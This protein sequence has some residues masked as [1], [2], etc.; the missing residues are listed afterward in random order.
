MKGFH[1]SQ[2]I[3]GLLLLFAGVFFTGQIAQAVDFEL[4]GEL[5]PRF[6]YIDQGTLGATPGNAKNYTTMRTRVNVKAKADENTAAFVQIQDVRTW[7]GETPTSAP[8]SLTRTGTNTSASGLDLHQA[9]I[10]LKDVLD[11]GV[12]LKIGRQE[13]IYDEH[14]LLGNINWI[15]QG[16]SHDAALADFSLGELA[17][18]AFVAQTIAND[19]HPTLAAQVYTAA[20][21]NFE[22]FF[23]GLRATYKLGDNGDRITPY[24]YFS[25]DPAN[26]SGTVASRYDNLH[27]AGAYFL[28]HFGGFRFR[29]DGAYQFGKFGVGTTATARQDVQAYM[30]TGAL[31]TDVDIAHGGGITLWYDYLSGDKDTSATST[32]YKTFNTLYA[33]NHAYYG[34]M[35]KFLNTPTRGLQDAAIKFWVKPTEKLK[36]LLDLHQ[37][38][39]AAT[40][41][42]EGTNLGQEVDFKFVYPLAANTK[43][44]GGYS[45]YF[46]KG[47]VSG[48]FPGDTTLNGNWAWAMVDMKF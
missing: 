1:F 23:G 43:L 42:G 35:D 2:G 20:G 11:S 39:R 10:D 12:S 33:T 14:R 29:F 36:L 5:R 32:K 27:T 44:I 47:T 6:E 28:K 22:S 8:P 25:Q 46:G 7:G 30:L 31:G 13:I 34:H 19:T 38:M 41:A 26:T 16:Q 18:T 48:G 9:Y 24:Y 15:Q 17:V 3:R 4:G 21:N 37:F 45:H 40:V